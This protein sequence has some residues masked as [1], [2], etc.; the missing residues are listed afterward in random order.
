MGLPPSTPSGVLSRAMAECGKP[1]SVL[2]D[3]GAHFYAAKY[4]KKGRGI[5]GFEKRP[6][7]A[8]MRHILAGVAHPQTN[9]KI[10][11]AHGKIQ[12]KPPPFFDAAGPPGGAWRRL[13]HRHARNRV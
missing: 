12:R 5:S 8:G 4:E 1:K 13:P 9:G 3:R 6:E 11:R 10:R 7:S 2:I